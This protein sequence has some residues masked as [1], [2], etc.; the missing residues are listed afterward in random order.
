MK[1]KTSAPIP[2]ELIKKAALF[3]ITTLGTIR[4]YNAFTA[5]EA[6]RPKYLQGYFYKALG[7]LTQTLSCQAFRGTSP[8]TIASAM[9]KHWKNK[10]DDDVIWLR[11][12]IKVYNMQD[13]VDGLDPDVIL[14]NVLYR[15]RKY[16]GSTAWN[17]K[18]SLQLF[19][20]ISPI[21]CAKNVTIP[22]ELINSFFPVNLF[23]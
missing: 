19:L 6:I 10:N 5:G 1:T 9:L 23:K 21:R 11:R 8:S 7:H 18:A 12:L 17:L 20:K 22:E 16:R 2:E 14:A 13:L 3:T 15:A 4:D